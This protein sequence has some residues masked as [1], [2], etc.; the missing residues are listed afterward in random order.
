VARSEGTAGTNASPAIT[1]AASGHLPALDGIRALAVLG[2]L[3]FHGGISWLPGGFLGVDAFFVL[4]GYLITTLLLQEWQRSGTIRLRAFWGRRARRLLPALLALLVFVSCYAAFAVPGTFPGLRGDALATLFYVANWHFILN[5]SNY[6]AQTGPV[7]PLTHTWSLAIE[8]QFYLVWPVVVLLVLRMWRG[9]R[10]LWWLAV[11]GTLGS[12]LEMALLFRAGASTTRLYDGTDTHAQSVLL[13]TVLALGLALLAE[14]KGALETGVARRW[15]PAPRLTTGVGRD[16]VAAAAGWVGV[17]GSIVLWSHIRGTSPLLYQGGFL[18]AGLAAAGVVASAVL[19][20]NGLLSRTLSVQPLPALGRISYGVYLW[21]YPLFLWVDGQRTGLEGYALFATRCAVTLVVASASYVAIERPIRRGRLLA[22]WKAWVAAPVGAAATALAVVLATVTPAVAAAPMVRST[23]L[24]GSASLRVLVIGD[25]TALTLGIALAGDAAT[26][27]V[28]ERDEAIL[29][30]GVTDGRLVA[31]AGTVVRVARPCS[32]NP[33]P[34]GTPQL[35]ST[36]T[37]YGVTAVTPDAEHWTAW[38]RHWVSV[39]RPDVVVLLAGRWEVVTRTFRGHWTNI[40][41]P[42]FAAYVRR[43]LRRTVRLAT[44]GGAHVVL[45]TAPCYDNGEQPDG[46]PWPTDAHSRVAVYNRLVRSVAAADPTQATV[47][48]LDGLVCPG[49]QFQRTLHG[50]PIRMA[51]G[52]HFTPAG[53]PV[54]GPAIW[55]AVV[56]AAQT[57]HLRRRP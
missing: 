37:P 14:R 52:I 26:Y 41:N 24:P 21:H 6:F 55:P 16:T 25:S 46:Q 27:G 35:E 5:G 53:G 23:A 29:G 20:P 49:G 40:L 28:T 11:A 18:L 15:Q 50:I 54:L 19:C 10:P 8:E 12:A 33:A 4:S 22:G 1:L 32:S 38:Y 51:D 3:A 43:Q 57:V 2:V 47:F 36:P 44:A 45:M 39:V 31:A 48:D 7:S 9:L 42:S 34:A 13:G 17:V 30:C 56:R